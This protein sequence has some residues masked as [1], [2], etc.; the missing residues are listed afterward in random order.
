MVRN[1]AT[2][3]PVVLPLKHLTDND[4]TDVSTLGTAITFL[5][6][7]KW[8]GNPRFISAHFVLAELC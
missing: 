2:L 8:A 7:L 1:V 3:L 5:Y 4:V 6:L